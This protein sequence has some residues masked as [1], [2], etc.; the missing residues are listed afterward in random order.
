MSDQRTGKKHY[1]PPD[2]DA[3]EEYVRRVCESSQVNEPEIVT[4]FADF[5]NSVARAYTNHL[6]KTEKGENNE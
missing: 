3:V 6:N 2:K 4:G 1:L 5:L